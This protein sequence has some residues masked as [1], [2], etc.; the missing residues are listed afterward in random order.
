M[1]S[2][3]GSHFEHDDTVI[4]ESSNECISIGYEQYAYTF[5]GRSAIEVAIKD[6]LINRR[7]KKV[8][9]PNYCCQSMIDPFISNSIDVEFYSVSL[10][11][12]N[13]IKYNIDYNKD[14]D[15]FFAISYFGLEQYDQE[16]IIRSFQDKNIIVIEDVTHSLYSTNS[17]LNVADYCVA[18][19]RK[20]L[21]IA[22]GGMVYK[23]IGK[24]LVKPVLG[25]NKYVSLKI[26]AM[27]DK[28]RYINGE[29]INKESFLKKFIES[30]KQL[31]FRDYLYKIDNYSFNYLNNVNLEEVR[32]IRR[33]NAKHLFYGINELKNIKSMFPNPDLDKQVP[34]FFPILVKNGK[35]DELRT[36]LI[37]NNV[38]CPV[39]WPKPK[40]IPNS[41]IVDIELSL[42]CDQRYSINEMEYIISLLK[43]W[44]K[45]F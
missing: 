25:S 21:P 11:S 42:I 6:I 29:K 30:D 45:E 19:L 10:D 37:E 34:L 3:I 28:L 26:E 32:G 12:R 22:S 7:I 35:R 4:K 5:S 18:S 15:V 31:E 27:K 33:R 17:N 13:G 23:R 2:E 41:C 39:H 38:Y 14:C 1:I 40:N 44:D 9:M 43:K 36:F 16:N 24:L 20:W 8:Y